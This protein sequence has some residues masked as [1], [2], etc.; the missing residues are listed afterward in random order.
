M[1]L[2]QAIFLSIA[3]HTLMVIVLQSMQAPKPPESSSV[4]VEIVPSRREQQVVRNPL[5]DKNF[6]TL[7]TE[8]KV[9]FLA[10]RVQR[11][12]E[13]TKAA[14]SGLSENRDNQV[15]QQ[16]KPKNTRSAPS[17]EDLLPSNERLPM[18]AR[19]Y[20]ENGGNGFSTVSDSLDV[21]VGTMTSLNTDQYLFSSFFNRV[22]ELVYLR[23]ATLVQSEQTRVAQRLFGR[24]NNDRWTT[25]IDVWVRPNGE[26]HSAHILKES[27]V[28][29]FDRAAGLAFQQARLFPNPPQELVEDDGFIHLK[30]NLTVYFDPKVLVHR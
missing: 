12:K 27:G 21:R 19:R 5:V 20:E 9:K 6:E 13:Q 1:R 30:Y 3:F 17:L 15:G 8:E 7:P 4:V 29:E 25:M 11:V 10:D 16:Q 23:W 14:L 28:R 2:L 24:T 22:G 18:S 26:Y